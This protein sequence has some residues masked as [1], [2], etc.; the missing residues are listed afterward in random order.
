MAKKK[1]EKDNNDVQNTM[2]TKNNYLLCVCILC[3][4]KVMMTAELNALWYVWSYTTHTNV[5]KS[6]RLFKYI[7]MIPIL[8]L[9]HQLY[10]S[11]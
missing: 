10:M 9:C 7:P 11:L 4:N 5:N 2:Y 6:W 8:T 1:E 3:I